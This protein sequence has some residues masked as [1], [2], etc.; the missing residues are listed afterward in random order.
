MKNILL[1]LALLLSSSCVTIKTF[2]V[3]NLDCN[4]AVSTQ[5][6]GTAQVVECHNETTTVINSF[7]GTAGIEPI[8]KALEAGMIVGG[9]YAVLKNLP[10]TV[11]TNSTIHLGQ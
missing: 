5:L 7:A 6:M 8:E 11:N 4:H 9:G 3:G 10:H 1:L 2:K